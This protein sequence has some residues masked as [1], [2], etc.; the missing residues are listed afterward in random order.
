METIGKLEAVSS[1]EPPAAARAFEPSAPVEPL[2]AWDVHGGALIKGSVLKPQTLNPKP[3][4]LNA[5]RMG[6]SIVVHLCF[7]SS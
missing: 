1:E 6:F 2:A 4:T 3:E 5:Y 7:K